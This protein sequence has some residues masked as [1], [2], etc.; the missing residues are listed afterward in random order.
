MLKPKLAD[1]M[2][3]FATLAMLVAPQMAK[4][5][6]AAV[7]QVHNVNVND[8]MVKTIRI[9]DSLH[10]NNVTVRY[11][12]VATPQVQIQLWAPKSQPERLNK[13]FGSVRFT[14]D[15]G[16]GT[17]D[18]SSNSFFYEC[19][20][21]S[22]NLF[23]YE[24]R[25]VSGACFGDTV[26][27]VLPQGSRIAVWLGASQVGG[28]VSQVVSLQGVLDAIGSKSFPDDKKQVVAQVLRTHPNLHLT[29]SQASQIVE[30]FDFN[31]DKKEIAMEVGV[32]VPRAYRLSFY[33]QI[34]GDLSDLDTQDV[35]DALNSA[36]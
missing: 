35:L 3:L 24:K 25:S 1:T 5:D 18:V 17:V 12:P 13:L 15:R 36:P 11:A 2:T 10:A 8:P 4:A 31:D 6:E 21:S 16:T 7:G 30:A 33:Q 28:P 29:A 22:M 14:V 9:E 26:T 32:H 23:G 27:V 19:S 34:Q 20:M